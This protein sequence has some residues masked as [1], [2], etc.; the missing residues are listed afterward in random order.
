[1]LDLQRPQL[2]RELRRTRRRRLV[3][4][5]NLGQRRCAHHAQ[6]ARREGSPDP[7]PGLGCGSARRA[8]VLVSPGTGRH[9]AAAHF[10]S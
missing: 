1:M 6:P 10:F 9:A 4:L 3:F 5:R 2:R 8:L 7:F